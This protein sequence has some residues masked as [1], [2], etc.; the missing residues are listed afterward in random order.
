MK[1]VK[2]TLGFWLVLAV[3][4]AGAKGATVTWD[5]GGGNN[6]WGNAANWSGD[7]LPG[8]A[9]DVVI[10]GTGEVI[11]VAGSTSVR[12]IHSS[13]DL[14]LTGGTIIVSAGASAINATLRISAGTLT[15]R[16]AAVLSVTGS[17]T[18][19]GGSVS[20]RDGG[21]V[22]LP[23]LAALTAAQPGD[24]TFGASGAGASIDL[25]NF[26]TST[27][28]NFYRLVIE[29][30]DGGEVKA[31]KLN[32]I[33]SLLDNGSSV[34]GGLAVYADGDGSSIDLSGFDNAIRNVSSGTS[35]IEVRSGAR[36]ILQP[37]MTALERVN[38]TVRGP[39]DFPTAQLARF[40]DGTL[41]LDETTNQFPNLTNL[42]NS[43]VYV[44]NGAKV[45]LPGISTLAKTNTGSITLSVQHDES[46]LDLP[47]LVSARGQPFYQ[48]E[49][50]AMDGGELSLPQLRSIEGAVDIFADGAETVVR[51]PAMIGTLTNSSP[52]EAYIE[53]R[54]GGA[55]EV[56]GITRFENVNLRIRDGGVI[57]TTQITSFR[58][59]ELLIENTQGNFPALVD[60]LGGDITLEYGAHLALAG[61]TQI[62][63]TNNG[64][65][66]LTVRGEDTVLELPNLTQA[67][68][69]NF[70][71]VEVFAY[72][73]GVIRL[74]RWTTLPGGALDAFADGA[75]SRVELPG[76][77]GK[78]ANGSSAQAYIES[79]G[80]GSIL[81]PNV[82][83]LER[84]NLALRGAGETTVAQISAFRNAELT[85]ANR[86]LSL[87]GLT[88]FGGSSI[89]VVDGG[90]LTLAGITQMIRTNSGSSYISASDAG[91]VVHLPNLTTA[92]VQDFY[93][94][95]L[96]AYS[97]GRIDLPRL[98]TV[99][100]A[101]D[102]FADGVGSTVSLPGLVG[103]LV[104]ASRGAA[105][106]EAR[107]GGAVLIPNVTGIDKFTVTLRG[108]GHIPTAQWTSIRNSN[109][110]IDGKNV[111]FS[112]LSDTS[113][114][115]FEYE[116]GGTAIFQPPAD[117]IVQSIFVPSTLIANQPFQAIWEIRN[118]GTAVTNGS[119]SDLLFLSLD[120]AIGGDNFLGTVQNTGDLPAGAARR[121]TNTITFPAHF[122]GTR[123]LGVV[124]NH[125][126]SLFEGTNYANNTNLS[127]AAIQ[128]QAPDLVVESAAASSANGQFG[129]NLTLN[130]RVRNQGTAGAAAPTADRLVLIKRGDSLSGGT[131]LKSVA[132]TMPLGAGASYDRTENVALPL[133][134]QFEDGEYSIAISTDA[135]FSNPESIETN[136]TRLVDVTLSRP[137]LPD[138]AVDRVLGGG[139]ARPGQELS[140]VW[141]ITNKGTASATSAWTELVYLVSTNG[142]ATNR[143]LGQFTFT[144]DLA[145]GSSLT[146]TQQLSIPADVR[147]GNA[148]LAVTVDAEGAV[149]ERNETNNT[150]A[151]PQ[152]T[153]IQPAL[154]IQTALNSIREDA[155]DPRLSGLVTRNGDLAEPLTV[156]LTSSQSTEMAVPATIVFRAGDLAVPFVMTV[157]QDGEPDVNRQVTIT[158]A[159]PGYFPGTAQ[160]TVVNSDAPSLTLRV[161][162]NSAV[163]GQVIAAT[164]SHDGSF[165]TPETVHLSATGDQQLTVPPT[166]TFA[167]GESSV[168]FDVTATDDTRIDAPRTY[169]IEAAGA[170]FLGTSTSVLV[171]DN[172]LGVFTLAL[173]TTNI[174]ESAGPNATMGIVSRGTPSPR[175]LV[176]EIE[177]LNG[178]E[179]SIP[180]SVVIPAGQASASFPIGVTD[181][182][183]VEGFRR[184][185]IKAY[186]LASTSGARV[187]ESEWIF[188]EVNDDDSPALKLR[189][190]KD[191]VAEGANPAATVTV[192]RTGN[193]N[194]ATT[195]SLAASD[196]TRIT[197]PAAV[198]IPIGQRSLDFQLSAP[199]NSAPEGNKSV[200]I[201]ATSF[202]YAEA[203][204]TIVVTDSSLPD[205]VVTEVA[206]PDTAE[207]EA[208]VNL[209]YRVVN[210]GL[211][212][213]GTNWLTQVYLSDDAQLGNDTLLA[214]SVF[215]GTLPVN[216]HF[217]QSRQVR[218]PIQP[219]DY[220]VIVVTDSTGTISEVLEHNNTSISAQPIRIR[221]AYNATVSADL[222]T[223]VAGT[224]VPLRGAV[225]KTGTGGPVPFA[226]A[227]IH[228][229]V[230]GT[231][232]VISALADQNGNFAATFTPLPGEA[233]LYEIGA[234]HP[235]AAT[236]PIQDSFTLHGVKAEAVQP[237]RLS[238]GGTVTGA[239]RIEN[240][241]DRPLTGL[242]ASVS[243]KPANLDVTVTV[244]T[245]ALNGL[246]SAN[247]GYAITARD[248]SIPAGAVLL[249]VTS[250]QG[251]AVNIPVSVTVD[252]LRPK[253]AVRPVEIVRGMKVGA[254]TFVEFE[255]VN[256]G[257]M[258]S[259]PVTIALPDA[260]WMNLITPSPLLGLPPGGTNKVTLQLTPGA[261]L[262]LGNYDGTIGLSSTNAQ[263]TVPFTFRALSEAR[264]DLLITAVDEYTFFA[265]GAPKVAGAAVTV[266]DAVTLQVITNGV[267][268]ANGQYSLKNIPEGYYE[269]E[270]RA[271]KHKTFREPHL[272][273]SGQTNE[274][275]AFL[276][277]EAV[278]YIWTVIPTEIQDRTK[279]TI[280]TLF[281]AFV[282]MPVI[283]VDPPLIDLADFKE[284][285]TQIDMRVMNHGLIAAKDAKLTFGDHPEWSIE[286]LVEDL[287]DIPARASFT[288]PVIV[289]RLSPGAQGFASG[290]MTAF[291][292][293]GCS[294][295]GSCRFV[296][297]CGGSA[298]GGSADVPVINA[299]ASGN[300]GGGGGGGIGGGGS[301]AGGGGG[302]S[303]GGPGNSSATIP[304]CNKCLLELF[305]CALD[306]ALPDVASC[307]KDLYGCQGAIRSGDGGQSA[308]ECMKAAINCGAAA[309][310]ESLGPIGKAIDIAECLAN[311]PPACL[312]GG[313]GGGG[314]GSGG[315]SGGGTGG[316]DNGF[317][318]ALAA[319]SLEAA[320]AQ[321]SSTFGPTELAIVNE[322]MKWVLDEV[323]PFRYLLG[324]DIWFR[325]GETAIA[326]AWLRAFLARVEPGTESAGKISTTELTEL[327]GV[328]LPRIMTQDHARTF[329]ARWNRSLDY[330]AAG[331][332]R[333]DQVPAG[334]NRDFIALDVVRELSEASD[335]SFTKAETQG[336]ATPDQALSRAREELMQYMSEGD[337]AGV[338]AQVRL[339]LEQEAVMTRDAFDA[340]LEIINDSATPIENVSIDVT[341]RRRNGQDATE[342]F[343]IRTPVLKNLTAID[344]T[345]VIAQSATGQATWILVP[346]TDAAPNGPEEFLVGGLLRYR[347]D[348]LN[349]TVPLA[350]ASITVL[351]SPS[352]AVKYFHER[353]VFADDPFTLPIEPSIPYSLA[354]MVQNKGRGAAR[355]VR[356]DSAQPKIVE[357]E[358]GLLADFKIIATEV[359]GQNLQPSLTVDFGR[360]DPGTNVIG[361]W[362]LTSTILGGFI[363]YS[364]HFEH[365]D[366]LGN[367]NL[368][369]V[370]GIEIHE[371]IHVVRAGGTGDDGRP[372]FLANDIQDLYDRP[373]TLHLSDGTVQPVSA[374]FEGAFDGAPTTNDLQVRL[375]ANLPPGHAYLRV[376]DPGNGKFRLK[377]ITRSNGSALPV[378][379]YW[380]TDRTFLGNARR[381]IVENNVHLFDS[382]GGGSYILHYEIIPAGDEAPPSSSVAQLSA[383][384]AARFTV[385]WSGEDNSGGSG[386]SIYDVYVSVDNGPFAVWL[387]QTID[388]SA[389][390]QGGFGRNYAFYSIATDAAGNREAA[391]LTADARTTVTRT[392]RAPVLEVIANKVVREGETL[393]VQ[394]VAIDPDNDELTYSLMTNAPLGTVIHPYTGR[395]TWATSE[396]SGPSSYNF[397]VQVLDNGAPRLGATRTFQVTVSDDNTPPL[398]TQVL[399][400][401]V[402]EAQTIRFVTLATDIDLPA[403]AISFSL[404][405]GAP[406]GSAIEANSGEFTW[407]PTEVQG[408]TA[409]RIGVV[410][411]DNGTPGL[412]STQHF[413][414]VV[415]DTRSDLVLTVGTT[416]V[417][418]GGTISAPVTLSSGTDLS[419]L[420]FEFVAND[421]HLETI[422]LVPTAS[423]ILA[424][425]LEFISDGRFRVAFEFDATR[426]QTGQ[427]QIG[428]LDFTTKANGRSSVV[429]LQAFGLE[430]TRENGEMI[431]R[432][433]ARDGRLFLIEE[434][435]I[436]DT[437]VMG[438]NT[439]RLVIYAKPGVQ[440]VIETRNAF[441][442][443]DNW[444]DA[445]GLTMTNSWFIHNRQVENAEPG[446]F[447]VRRNN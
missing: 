318:A 7:A 377:Q 182:D 268:G 93:Q 380:T 158:A 360:I 253:L 71:Q 413:N 60:L 289:R 230:R 234:A 404:A 363:E 163:E 196:R 244:A 51:L 100:G 275:Q 3:C 6:T 92:S 133:T 78:L 419:A 31:P 176:V 269:L 101:L 80:G 393:E 174:S 85:V 314:G 112:G 338:C 102:A 301:P 149:T 349:V 136:N 265:E 106:L 95:E 401:T 416:N 212:S 108:T 402:N 53:A 223:A 177:S 374:V 357:N 323:A 303:V 428:R 285:V 352:L 446:Y 406:S 322:R 22:N 396:G 40:Q 280:E 32:S 410:A 441:G 183:V 313:G 385:N 365:L 297:E 241:G 435:P 145:V 35:R 370:E 250:A 405:P 69:L 366:G 155:S 118:V 202:S 315:G 83:E 356:I 76:F 143:L 94:F 187:A 291:G 91:S 379:N 64:N 89:S 144:N 12:S 299:S 14:R 129:Q 79:R 390:Y 383:D 123:Y 375:T 326:A 203:K 304:T 239:V 77:T 107:N 235:G 353:Q 90:Q 132:A 204:T 426:A 438:A 139:T 294:I 347:Q 384:S 138:L 293:G 152:P 388:Q 409:Y 295:A 319:M 279:I 37:G 28:Q 25:P 151:A 266:R 56:A 154:T 254:Q 63:R 115:R 205:L 44:E 425:S 249:R 292:G 430:A 340:T 194:F 162:T 282:P 270:L 67:S 121:F 210:Q 165:V 26:T 160:V 54:S 38:L 437:P 61:V 24:V 128:I 127:A 346:T 206:G 403:Q 86:V 1:A 368:S 283:T 189:L 300:C 217:G 311:V 186:A 264:G 50:H 21:R 424:A 98:S 290:R 200:D 178:A 306:L 191:L 19:T 49:L 334:Q 236:A 427:R 307:A 221:P 337:G 172:D 351:P 445:T 321:G 362:L 367:K 8:P 440:C 125:T 421:G 110:L 378:D 99:T 325:N 400:M 159:A 142:S 423:E 169:H 395:I 193:T 296:I 47:N 82:T 199:A 309:G 433:A 46:R 33:N 431:A 192:S 245:N 312:G 398:I 55:I 224:V 432:T 34:S 240:L 359:A 364:A 156:V 429:S 41:L 350:P 18:M 109:V 242:A 222:E 11:H 111:I 216:Q 386:I 16:D 316:T 218:M 188:L 20:A 59:A 343:A 150:S 443:G 157:Q 119:W 213:A 27:V 4:V 198:T 52:G 447:R 164:L 226:L 17:M 394:P 215:N 13:R 96:S 407:R 66:A 344:G 5:G 439:A 251:A 36:V 408:G 411:A 181:N 260:P 399:D 271:D 211:A 272:V 10:N 126:R 166:I 42:Q 358:K 329:I 247:V 333:V 288:V 168:T 141:A 310:K 39:S 422:E 237:L 348:G 179:A 147:A 257:G 120:P 153:V 48:V 238:E 103:V 330:W 354:V 387:E 298:L 148:W 274:V 341:V 105:Y 74:P 84:I 124:V 391:P 262:P 339:R 267:T 246:G 442:A 131:T 276:R 29:A 305:K 185:A 72:D 277:R 161:A 113:G 227:N 248:G 335:A 397:T 146:R 88:E 45:T 373:D 43:S 140:V 75:G 208:F 219:G 418:A 444:V 15:A 342:L 381:P 122:A 73:G 173:S 117:L 233:G 135:H 281:E 2:R 23:S 116:N 261:D 336:Y 376:T 170:G 417:L 263:L 195:V 184:S 190:S 255:V 414:V 81:L 287:G 58:N 328:S 232:R 361:R 320:A 392:N 134:S 104:N 302:A 420:E 369:L 243:N 130:W 278:R 412:S 171:R 70:Y 284:E 345:G 256:E 434:E 332:T 252:S 9:D 114:T 273:L 308:Y 214:E 68:T 286:P 436:L 97:G 175:S 220:W 372:D 65:V 87:P 201:V 371:M 57:P 317:S 30:T 229:N 137:P 258:A 355:D 389:I 62:T 324:D 209:S 225:T 231:K 167:A 207:T 415:R 327:L 259:G 180:A 197:I 382:N 228:I 331:I